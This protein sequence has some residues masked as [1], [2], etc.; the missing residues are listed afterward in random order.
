MKNQYYGDIND[1]KKYSLIRHL[2]GGGELAAAV[3]WILTEDDSLSDGSKINYL[4]DPE[5]WRRYD[6]IVF[7]KLR[8]DVLVLG[9]RSV[10]NLE[11][12]K[13]LTNCK[14][15]TKHIQDE[16]RERDKFFNEFYHFSNDVDLIFFD[17]DNGLEIKSVPR[18]RSKSSKYLYWNELKLFYNTGSS[19]LLYQHFPRQ[20]REYYINNLVDRVFELTKTDVVFSYVTSH[21]LF[22]LIPQLEHKFYFRLRNMIISKSWRG[23]IKIKEHFRD[24]HANVITMKSNNLTSGQHL[25]N[26]LQISVG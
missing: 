13:I 3:C 2:T 24:S 26:F 16:I 5:K 12:S 19:I 4:R 15:Y 18:G 8:K 25:E 6:P 10:G 11:H 1:Y 17:P 9:V 21:V 20:N 14:F 23:Q 22:L 7:E